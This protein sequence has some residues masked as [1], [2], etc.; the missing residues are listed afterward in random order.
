M[1]GPWAS[2][3]AADMLQCVAGIPIQ[4]PADTCLMYK[5]PRAGLEMLAADS[6]FQA[7]DG[8]W[9]VFIAS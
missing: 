4:F 6:R 5:E 1:C 9:R 7:Q 8:R 3:K 2:F